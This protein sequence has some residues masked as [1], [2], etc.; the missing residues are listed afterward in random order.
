MI[1]LQQA[2]N[3]V[4]PG[5]TLHTVHFSDDILPIQAD[6]ENEEGKATCTEPDYIKK[7]SVDQSNHVLFLT[8]TKI[9]W[10][11]IHA[12]DNGYLEFR[13]MIYGGHPGRYWSGLLVEA[14]FWAIGHFNSLDRL[15]NFKLTLIKSPH[16]CA[17]IHG[18]NYSQRLHMDY[19]VA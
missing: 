4:I 10:L 16:F 2:M 14:H 19:A 6:F 18:N 1:H 9:M 15:V 3:S 17:V 12:I 8:K 13:A 7:I 11:M 5:T